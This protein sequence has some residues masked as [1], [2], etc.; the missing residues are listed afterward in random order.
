MAAMFVEE[1][2]QKQTLNFK[3]Y[4]LRTIEEFDLKFT[5]SWLGDSTPK[6]NDSGTLTEHLVRTHREM[7][8]SDAH[9]Y[10]CMSSLSYLT[11]RARLH[12]LYESIITLARTGG[13]SYKILDVGSCIGQETRALI[14]DGV[15]PSSIT[16]SDVHDKYWKAGRCIFMDN[17]G[18]RTDGA[19]IPYS[20]DEV[21]E[22]W[23]DWSTPST[24]TFVSDLKDN[25]DAVLCKNVH[26]ALSEQQSECFHARLFR[27]LKNGGIVFGTAVGRVSARLW[28]RNPEN[29]ANRYL[30]SKESLEQSL[31]RAGFEE[32]SIEAKEK[33]DDFEGDPGDKKDLHPQYIEIMR[34]RR[35]LIFSARKL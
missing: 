2:I 12:P 20:I 18:D 30:H 34:D 22:I 3:D 11:P 32:I 16:T 14:V 31:R 27:V 1:V 4:P 33:K 10:S 9:I 6:S 24:D 29:T 7:Q 13:S 25:F 35:F 28:A 17:E 23:G 5:R 21:S 15:C 26:H 19:V 8:S